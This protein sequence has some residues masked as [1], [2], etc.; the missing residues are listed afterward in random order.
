MRVDLTE[1]SP[2]KRVMAI[3]IETD[4]MARETEG[5]LRNYARKAK[6]PGFRPG[7]APLSVIRTRFRKEVQDD[8]RE[9]VMSRCFREATR[10]RGLKPLGDPDRSLLL[11]KASRLNRQNLPS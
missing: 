3:E 5:V 2:V 10:E 4:E 8:V 6:I 7:K 11:L 9:R 1:Q